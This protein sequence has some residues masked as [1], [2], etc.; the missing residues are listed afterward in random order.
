MRIKCKDGPKYHVHVLTSSQETVSDL[1]TLGAFIYRKRHRI[2]PSGTQAP[3]LIDARNARA[4]T[5]KIVHNVPTNRDVGST[6]DHIKPGNAT[7]CNYH[8]N[9]KPT[10]NSIRLTATNV[11]ENHS[12]KQ[13]NLNSSYRSGYQKPQQ[14]KKVQKTSS[15]EP[16]CYWRT[17]SSLHHTNS[18]KCT[19]STN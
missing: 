13:T 2:E 7:T 8:Q 12:R 11:K 4:T 3:V 17:T 1:L 18:S 19:T 5:R 6:L 10:R 16:T 9:A 14:Q 15:I